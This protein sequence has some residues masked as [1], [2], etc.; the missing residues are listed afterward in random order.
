[1]KNSII[2]VVIPTFKPNS[3]LLKKTLFSILHQS[4]KPDQVVVVEN[5]EQDHPDAIKTLVESFGFKYIYNE[6]AGANPAR[7]LGASICKDGILFFTDDDCELKHDCLER[8]LDVHSKGNFIVGGKVDLKYNAPVPV[9]MCSHFESMLAKLDWTPENVIDGVILDITDNRT[10]Y[11][12]S[13]N[14]SIKSDSFREYGGFDNRD[15]YRGKDLLTTNDEMMLLETCRT[16]NKTRLVFNSFCQIKHNIPETRLTEEYMERRFY[17]QGIADAKL[18][19]RSPHLKNIDPPVDLDDHKMI[20]A[21]SLLKF[22]VG[23]DH[24]SNLCSRIRTGDKLI[25]REINKVFMI[26]YCKYIQG[27]NDF[28]CKNL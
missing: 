19:V 2:S 16:S 28:L 14:L 8:H 23:T 18:S 22:V 11:L 10:Q 13:A 1:M 20:L 3:E 15:G 25:D 21:N 7:N 5:G 9:W 6:E 12:V 27:I 26:C 17:G 4:I 24:Y